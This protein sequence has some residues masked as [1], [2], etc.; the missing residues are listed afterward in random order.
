MNV[1]EPS[2]GERG[3]ALVIV[4]VVLALALVAAGAF[5]YLSRPAAPAP[6]HDP[7][8]AATEAPAPAAPEPT[9]AAPPKPEPDE[10]STPAARKPAA[11][12][13]PAAKPAEAPAEPAAPTRATLT[14]ESDVPGASVFV[15]RQF[16]GN[17]PVTLQNVAPGQ[18]RINLSADGFDGIAREVDVA[19]GP[20]TVSMR[21][22]EVR[23]NLR[24][25]VV[26]KHGV[27]SCS[28]ELVAT[29]DGLRYVTTNTKDAGTIPFD[30]LEQFEVNY[31]EKNLRVRQRGGK[32]WNFTNPE[33]NADALFVF[34]RDVDAARKK[35]AEGYTPV[36]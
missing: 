35:L 2:Q 32:T 9:P 5:Y 13:K 27:G 28:G 20:Q 1:F 24:M 15:D 26:H 17:A 31:L 4:A 8:H 14:I 18:K 22:K 6:D 23:L 12:P 34:Q 29:V 11:A 7:A 3:Q 21:F 36:R 30:S 16:V 33:Q 25:P 10:P 19:A